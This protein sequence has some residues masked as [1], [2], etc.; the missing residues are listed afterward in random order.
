MNNYLFVSKRREIKSYLECNFN[1]T[2]FIH[3]ILTNKDIRKIVNL[4][5]KNDYKQ[6]IIEDYVI[7]IDTILDKMIDM[8]VKVKLIWTGSLGTLNSDIELNSLIKTLDLL[9]QNKINALAFTDDSMYE[10]YR[11]I[12]NVYK[13]KYTVTNDTKIKLINNKN[14]GIFGNEFEWRSNYFNQISAIKMLDGYNLIGFNFK[15]I[16]KKYCKLFDVNYFSINNKLNDTLFRKNLYNMSVISCVEFSN[17]MD[18]YVIDAFNH[19]IPVIVGNNTLFF[20]GTELEK[21]II[22]NSDD[23]IDEIANKLRYALKNKKSIIS[24]YDKAKKEYD[25]KAASLRKTFMAC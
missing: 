1:N 22:V 8:N 14:I 12:N 13:I 6:I 25:K 2:I 10:I 18:L 17:Y 7:G 3:S 21:C 4:V 9:K 19:G 20:K 16:T 23:D 11:D 15:K 24:I 5:K